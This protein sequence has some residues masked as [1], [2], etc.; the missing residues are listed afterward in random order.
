MRHLPLVLFA[1]FVALGFSQVPVFVQE[2]E[3][4]LG[5]AMDELARVIDQD[6]AN[7]Q[8][9]GM[10]LN[11]FLQKH[12]LSG[13]TAFHKTG[14][15]MRDRLDRQAQLQ[16]SVRVLDSAPVWQKPL[17]V[18]QTAN[19]DM[20]R[21]TWEKFSATLTLN[22]LFGT[23]GLLLALLLRDI[24]AWIGRALFQRAPARRRQR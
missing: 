14:K 15:A 11:A 16:E 2:Y 9:V 7:A 20:M 22:P 5:G 23:V 17:I 12:E 6:R 18:A 21:R 10:D 13:D 24:V 4:R 1:L 3:Q 19:R 8:A